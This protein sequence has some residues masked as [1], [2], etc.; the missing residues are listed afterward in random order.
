MEVL[1]LQD[2]LFIGSQAR[3]RIFDLDI[4]MPDMLYEEVH[5]IDERIVLVDDSCELFFHQA[6]RDETCNDDEV[7]FV[8]SLQRSFR[9]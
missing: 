2:L 7:L 5:E 6:F 9:D 3:P 8:R 4:K 1:S